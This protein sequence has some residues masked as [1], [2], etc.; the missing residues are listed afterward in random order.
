MDTIPAVLREAAERFGERPAYV[1]DLADGRRLTLSFAGLADRVARTATAYRDAGVRRGDRI[2]VWAPNSTAW[3]VA[4][5]AVSWAGATLVPANTRY[6]G[7][8][9]AEIVERVGAALVVVED[10]FLGRAQIDELRAA[11][12]ERTVVT[13]GSVT[14]DDLPDGAPFEDQPGPDDVADILFTSGTTG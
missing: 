14:R 10:G 2:V 6:L 7:G 13:L 9:V 8:E 5:L 3:A 1:E 11:G 4:A 12:V